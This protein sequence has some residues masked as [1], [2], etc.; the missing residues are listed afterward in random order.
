M[1]S[2]QGFEGPRGEAGS[3]GLPGE[4]GKQGKFCFNVLS[5]LDVFLT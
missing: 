2:L 3:L 4:K 1:I 5:G